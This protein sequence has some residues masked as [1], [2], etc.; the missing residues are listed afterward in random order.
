MVGNGMGA[1][2]GVMFKTASSLEET[3]K[4]QIVALDKTGTITSGKPQ[5]TDMLPT[6]GVTEK[7]LLTMAYALEKKSEHRWQ[8]QF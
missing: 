6:E 1:K 2:H 7:E 3:G 5:V 4:M 8:E